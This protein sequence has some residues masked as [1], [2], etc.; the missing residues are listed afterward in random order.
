MSFKVIERGTNRKLVYEL[1][2][3]VYSR[4]IFA[5]SLTV[6]EVAYNVF[7]CSNAEDHILCIPHL[8]LTLNLE[9]ETTFGARR[10]ESWPC[11]NEEIMTVGRTLWAKR[12]ESPSGKCD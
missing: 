5:I 10:L 7:P 3:V 2:L 11:H 1:L 12:T 6:S 9:V 8:Y 4:L